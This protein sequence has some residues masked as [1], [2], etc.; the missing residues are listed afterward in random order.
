MKLWMKNIW[1]KRLGGLRKE[2]S[3]LVWDMF[4]SHLTDSVKATLKRNNTVSAVIPGGLTSL[5]Q[6]LDVSLNKP[7]KDNMRDKWNEWMAN[8]DKQF[9]KGGN[10][11][12][13]S[14]EL[15]CE[16]VKEA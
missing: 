2:K 13:P 5:L 14:L 16:F 4:R 6:P 7:F 8:G 11:R 1:S 9:T 12:A 10:M 3:I 15:L